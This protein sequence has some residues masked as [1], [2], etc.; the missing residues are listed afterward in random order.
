MKEIKENYRKKGA[1]R[2]D[3]VV[4]TVPLSSST[5]ATI[6]LVLSDLELSIIA[7]SSIIWIAICMR[8]N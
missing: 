7:I 4:H 2:S 5:N 3:D 1:I 8:F 6:Y